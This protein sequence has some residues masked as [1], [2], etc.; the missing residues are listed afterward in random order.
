MNSLSYGFRGRE[1][2]A[3]KPDGVFRVLVLG[4][5]MVFGSGVRPDETIPAH[6][7]RILNQKQGMAVYHVLNFGRVG[8]SVMDLLP[9]YDQTARLFSPDLVVLILCNNDAE[10][11]GVQENYYEHCVEIWKP[12]SASWPFFLDSF[13]SIC[14]AIDP[15]PL[16]VGYY[17]LANDTVADSAVARL[18]DMCRKR[19]LSFLN[20]QEKVK[21]VPDH[22]ARA[23]RADGHPSGFVHRIA[24]IEICKEL[25]SLD[26]LPN[27]GSF[28]PFNPP[29]PIPGA[30]PE[31]RIEETRASC[32]SGQDG[33]AK[34][35]VKHFIA[36]RWEEAAC[37][38]YRNRQNRILSTWWTHCQGQ[39]GFDWRRYREY[40]VSLHKGIGILKTNLHQ[41][42]EH[43]LNSDAFFR[44]VMDTSCHSRLDSTEEIL[45]RVKSVAEESEESNVSP[46]LKGWCTLMS[47]VLD[48]LK[49]FR[50]EIASIQP[51]EGSSL[52]SAK[53]KL[54]SRWH[55]IVKTFIEGVDAM[56]LK[57]F[58]NGFTTMPLSPER[59]PTLD[60]RINLTT[61]LPTS[62]S[63][64][65]NGYGDFPCA[66]PEFAYTEGS[67]RIQRILF[68]FPLVDLFD[69]EVRLIGAGD[70]HDFEYR[71]NRSAWRS[72]PLSACKPSQ[73]GY[74]TTPVRPALL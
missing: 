66:I 7:E 4:D 67:D 40:F 18:S 57:T 59:H 27:T 65:L 21:W 70:F 38:V 8:Y 34:K 42:S 55:A 63:L 13:S 11:V 28:T 61:P 64:V 39:A 52:Q 23:S 25:I 19:G 54:L 6:M 2:P 33:P 3:A 46:F 31:W 68:Q 71:V 58:L 20:L 5:S 14:K 44:D 74:L 12:E 51:Q 16:I 48:Q 45:E 24:A 35:A 9:L 26:L 15:V 62:I 69:L 50:T 41:N 10:V 56:E 60:I 30:T 53:D 43:F 1:Y 32:V 37:S 73:K 47:W 22:R 72:I 36:E 49:Q 17:G 29:H